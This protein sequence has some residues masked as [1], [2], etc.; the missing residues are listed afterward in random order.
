MRF[1]LFVAWR[2]FLSTKKARFINFISGLAVLGVA[3]GT[4]AL[5]II[6]SVFNGLEDLLR[7][8]H[9]TINPE[10]KIEKIEGK[11]FEVSESF[12]KELQNIEGVALVT[13]TI[14]DNVFLIYNNVQTVA[15]LKGVGEN[16]AANTKM[17]KAIY[18][19]EFLLQKGRGNYAVLG[20]GLAHMLRINIADP[21]TT[22]ECWY[23]KRKK[24]ISFG[25]LDASSSIN[26]FNILPVGVFSLEESYDVSYIFVPLRFAEKLLDYQDRCSYL[27]VQIQEDANSIDVQENLQKKLGNRYR[28]LNGDE[29][30]ASLLKALQIEKLFVYVALTVI[31]GVA[32]LNIFFSLMM[33]VLDKFKDIAMLY[34]MGA[35]ST[36]IRQIFLMEGSFISFVGTTTGLVLGLT[37]SWLQQNYGIIQMGTATTIVDAYPIKI[38]FWDVFFT[39]LTIVIITLLAT[40]FPALKATRVEVKTQL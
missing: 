24:K 27:E 9:S 38:E 6:L 39:V 18:D 30:Q 13:R 2:Y 25:S 4:M 16:Y 20:I 40:V 7:G 32:S 31:L 15:K 34:A 1:S 11:S 37:I 10:L 5:I 33:L 28:V 8:L 26:Q 35:S 21:F 3:L 17:K 23:P 12:I 36:I 19:G 22:I 14:E 29:Q